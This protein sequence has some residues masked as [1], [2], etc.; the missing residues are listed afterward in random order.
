MEDVKKCLAEMFGT[1]VLVMFGVGAAIFSGSELA[2]AFAFGIAVIAAAYSIGHISGA[3]LNPAISLGAFISGRMKL[4]DM[5][6]YVLSQIIGGIL[7]A[8][9]IFLILKLL[10][11]VD[12]DFAT[13]G[14]GQNHLPTLM[15]D[16]EFGKQLAVA[17]IF[18]FVATF[19]FVTVALGATS[20]NNPNLAIAG[21]AIGFTLVAIHILGLAITGVSVN[22]ARS[23]GPA[24]FAAIMDVKEALPQ[25]WVFIVAPLC[26]GAVAGIIYRERKP[27]TIEATPAE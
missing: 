23:I 25:L 17:L 5:L 22:P 10:L 14:L 3:H 13:L 27:K 24:I 20:K 16:L 26:G 18:E 15:Q 21:L 19:I 8:G 7:G 6:K 11:P 2:I 12:Y 9:I 1:A 4:V